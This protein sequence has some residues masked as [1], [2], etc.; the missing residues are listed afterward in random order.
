MLACV[1]FD[2]GPVVLHPQPDVGSRQ[3]LA[4]GHLDQRVFHFG[5]LDGVDG[6]ADQIDHDPTQL[7]RIAPQPALVV[8]AADQLDAAARE[9]IAEGLE[10]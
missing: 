10:S 3:V 9:A 6:V 1:C 7:L 4:H 2:A 5:I 8:D